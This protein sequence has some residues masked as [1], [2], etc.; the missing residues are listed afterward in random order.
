MKYYEAVKIWNGK[1][2][3]AYCNPKKGS[4]Q[5]EE[6][7]MIMKQEKASATINM[8]MKGKIARS[9]M[10]SAKAAKAPPPPPPA[11]APAKPVKVVKPRAPRKPK[12]PK[13]AP[14]PA[15]ILSPPIPAPMP[16]PNPVGGKTKPTDP[17]KY[18]PDDYEV[19]VFEGE[20]GKKYRDKILKMIR[21]PANDKK[22]EKM[23][24]QAMLE[25]AGQ[26]VEDNPDV[27]AQ[28]SKLF[29]R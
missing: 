26:W 23:I 24:E 21:N 9:A 12:A 22:I 5:Y 1:N 17:N 18:Q 10:A 13:V 15:P 3:G 25:D 7:K 2:T 8:A 4:K 11:S 14:A 28:F 16:M 19:Q 20:G 6:V 27:I 29:G